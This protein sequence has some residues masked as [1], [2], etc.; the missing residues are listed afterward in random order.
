MLC[1]DLFYTN[2]IRRDHEINIKY[3]KK[4]QQITE[5]VTSCDWAPVPFLWWAAWWAARH[6]RSRCLWSRPPV[7]GNPPSSCWRGKW[8]SCHKTRWWCP[9][10]RSQ[11]ARSEEEEATHT[12][13]QWAHKP[14]GVH[15]QQSAFTLLSPL[16][17]SFTQPTSFF[18][19]FLLIY[20]FQI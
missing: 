12:H 1:A 18:I 17:C 7:G 5:H 6:L 8:F 3:L 4:K 9:S 16:L 20:S 10:A 14:G 19:L 13:E 11:T 2:Y 15:V